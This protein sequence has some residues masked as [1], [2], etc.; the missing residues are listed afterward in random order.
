MH[1]DASFSY[2][3]SVATASF[4]K[5]SSTGT[6]QVAKNFWGLGG[7]RNPYRNL[8]SKNSQDYAQKPQRN[9]MFMN[10]A[11]VHNT[12]TL[13]STFLLSRCSDRDTSYTRPVITLFSRRTVGEGTM[14]Y[15]KLRFPEQGQCFRLEIFCK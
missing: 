15:T 9:W 7:L 12:R 11:S 14:E 13:R 5:K 8:K 2:L 1:V 4:D 10:S 6:A 3:R